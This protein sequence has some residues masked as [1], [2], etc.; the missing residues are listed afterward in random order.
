MRSGSAYDRQLPR[1]TRTLSKRATFTARL[2]VGARTRA[3]YV[4]RRR[5]LIAAREVASYSHPLPRA[6]RAASI[7]FAAP[8]FMIAS[9]R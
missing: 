9:E 7:R 4:D 3:R 2:S 1:L 8:I 5:W 6:I